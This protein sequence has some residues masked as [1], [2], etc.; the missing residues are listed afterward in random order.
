[1]AWLNYH[2]LYYFWT[3]ARL[4]SVTAAA[5]E[6]RIAQPTISGQLR[7]LERSLGEK[8]FARS[9]RGLVLTE[10]GRT[11]MGYAEEIFSLGRELQDNLH[12]G[13]GGRPQ[14]FVVGLAGSVP[15]LLAFQ[16]LSPALRLSP[17]LQLACRQG[18]AEQLLSELAA[19]TLDLVITDVPVGPGASVRAFNHLLG[20]CGV[21]FA[22][23]PSLAARL[24]VDF[25][26][27]LNGA[28]MVLPGPHSALRRSLS[29]WL[30]RHGLHPRVAAEC[31]DSALL[32]SF[33]ASGLGA[34]PVPAVAEADVLRHYN[35]ERIGTADGLRE[36]FYAIS[37]ERRVKHRGVQAICEAARGGTFLGVTHRENR[38]I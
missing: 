13:S 1:M 2:H 24:R 11:V 37:L 15:K 38:S 5:A 7:E 12:A 32:K 20:E 6:L 22:A 23:V 28:P 27:S 21:L 9:G 14:R 8:L 18:P 4:G 10:K 29:A 30:D 16:L 25:P 36:S 3:V 35:L 26:S 17:P 34:V 33:G 31:D 19:H